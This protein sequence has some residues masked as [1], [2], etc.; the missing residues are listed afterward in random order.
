MRW[1]R[2]VGAAL[3]ALVL[4]V[5][6]AGLFVPESH[7]AVVTVRLGRPP[8]DVWAVITDFGKLPE[9]NPDVTATERLLDRDGR[10]TWRED[11]D[12]FPATV[13]TTA[14]EPPARLVRE[15]LPEGA[16]FGTWTWELAAEGEGTRLT[17]T[18]RGTVS[19]PFFRGMMVFHDNSRTARDYA[20]ALARRLGT[21]SIPV[22]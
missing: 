5:L 3:V 2:Y 7:E 9:W 13:V 10:E 8:A 4:A 17:I 6:V 12:G 16:F 20:A 18:E 19:N 15:I 1:V 22:P 21:T 14:S 11:Y